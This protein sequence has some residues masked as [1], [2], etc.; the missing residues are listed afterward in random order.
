MRVKR[1]IAIVDD[2]TM[3]R[4]GLATL[5][6]MFDDYEILFDAAN[7]TEF[8]EKL[9][10]NKLPDIALLDIQMPMMDGYHTAEWITKNFP[11]IKI[12][13][14]STMD[15]ETAIIRM[16]KNGAKGYVLKEAEPK[17]LR[18]AF[19]EVIAEGYFYND[20]ITRKIMKSLAM[21]AND[22]NNIGI[23]ERLNERELQFL[24]MACS[25]RSY[26]EIA[27]E[28]FLSE[29]T[30]DGYRESLFKKCKVNTRVGLVLYAIKNSLVQ[31]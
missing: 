14:L 13:V 16:I 29:R 31:I 4:R 12:L 9:N 10:P 22:K 2:H 7:G 30:I 25:E 28:M 8:V 6:N 26:H 3:F 17:E 21:L 5:I 27:A 15:A 24:Q 11:Q 19:D 23:N 20:S 1:S 18:Q